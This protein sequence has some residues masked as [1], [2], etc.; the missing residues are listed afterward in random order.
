[1]AFGRCLDHL[2][3]P[4]G[5][6]VQASARAALVEEEAVLRYSSP[7]GGPRDPRDVRCGETLEE[8]APHWMLAAGNPGRRRPIRPRHGPV[9]CSLVDH[10]A[11]ISTI[12]DT[13]RLSV[14]PP[15]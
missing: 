6:Q 10:H 8:P 14:S 1:M 13:D 2:D 7:L 11:M 3:P 4:V 5:E 15:R 9:P 12:T